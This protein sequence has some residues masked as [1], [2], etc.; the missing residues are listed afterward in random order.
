MKEIRFLEAEIAS[1]QNELRTN[2]QNTQM[3]EYVMIGEEHM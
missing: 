3:R 2:I 1:Y